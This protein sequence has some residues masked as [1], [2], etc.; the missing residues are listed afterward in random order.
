MRRKAKVTF[1]YYRSKAITSI[2]INDC[3]FLREFDSL[4][5]PLI[6]KLIIPRI[7]LGPVLSRLEPNNL[8]TGN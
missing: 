5:L 7:L 8:S 6:I 1:K 4:R 2:Y 3:V